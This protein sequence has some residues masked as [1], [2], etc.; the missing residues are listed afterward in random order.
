MIPLGLTIV[1][2]LPF[3]GL[4]LLLL[5]E[6]LDAEIQRASDEIEPTP[7]DDP[8]DWS[9]AGDFG[10]PGDKLDRIAERHTQG[11]YAEL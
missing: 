9:A 3:A 4:G 1:A 6:W 10:K 7:R 5:V 8:Y 2:A 11:A